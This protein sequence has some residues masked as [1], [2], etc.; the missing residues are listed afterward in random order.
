MAGGAA[1]PMSPKQRAFL[2]TVHDA[3]RARRAA[4]LEKHQAKLREKARLEGEAEGARN[5]ALAEAREAQERDLA[6]KRA[7]EAIA[8]AALQQAQQ[9]HWEATRPRTLAELVAA[10]F[11][12]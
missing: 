8:F 7:K 9:A 6:E 1:P 3:R 5:L 10:S 12:D 11:K 2:Q 4:A